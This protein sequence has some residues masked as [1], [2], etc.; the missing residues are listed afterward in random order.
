ML[1][2]ETMRRPYLLALSCIFVLPTVA[3]GNADS[4][5]TAA[6]GG[7]DLTHASTQNV[8]S[9]ADGNGN[10]VTPIDANFVP[11]V[12]WAETD[13]EEVADLLE[14]VV[15]AAASA[16]ASGDN[17]DVVVTNPNGDRGAATASSPGA[18]GSPNLI[19]PNTTGQHVRVSLQFA[20]YATPTSTLD[21]NLTAYVAPKST[22]ATTVDGNTL[23]VT[24]SYDLNRVLLSGEAVHVA[25]QGNLVAIQAGSHV[26]GQVQHNWSG[27]VRRTSLGATA[28]NAAYDVTL[29][30]DN[31]SVVD[32][33]AGDAL[34]SRT[35][36]AS[37]ILTHV[38]S[39]FPAAVKL[40][41][42]VR[43]SPDRCLCPSA[44]SASLSYPADAD[45]PTVYLYTFKGCGTLSVVVPPYPGQPS[46][47]PRLFPA[48][49]ARCTPN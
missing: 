3:C 44:G 17:N 22:S 45:E 33:Y 48:S 18:A 6:G 37:L 34:Q 49:F 2:G 9:S 29:A 19:D 35:V 10:A 20:A 15:R 47:V 24:L 43:T 31:T 28:A 27:V 41:E 11:P 8:Q 38:A 32:R 39:N 30:H 16:L 46:S 1:A 42:V 5:R 14:L 13:A 12:Q 40:D 25:T 36:Q 23:T 26:S 21:G 7:N 4:S